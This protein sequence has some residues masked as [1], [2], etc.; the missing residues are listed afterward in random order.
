MKVVTA[1][2]ILAFILFFLESLAGLANTSII[3][4]LEGTKYGKV[5]VNY[6]IKKYGDKY[7]L[8]LFFALLNYKR[9]V[10]KF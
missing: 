10:N 7:N 6:L 4:S 2:L 5:D 3:K 9:K 1:L 8:V